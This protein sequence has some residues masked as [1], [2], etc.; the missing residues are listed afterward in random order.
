MTDARLLTYDYVFKSIV[1]GDSGVGKSSL[2]A[3]LCTRSFDP[4]YHQTIGVDFYSKILDI[5]GTP[6]KLQM[7]DLCGSERFKS[8]T[9]SYYRNATIAFV[10]YDC[11]SQRTFEHVDEWVRLV[12][13]NCEP[14]CVLVLVHHKIDLHN[15]DVTTDQ[16]RS[17][18]REHNMLFFETSSKTCHG[19]DI[20][21][22]E[23][24][25]EAVNKMVPLTNTFE[26]ENVTLLE[27][28]QD[29]LCSGWC[30]TM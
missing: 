12:R 18:A 5:K 24:V 4:S 16:G 10:V 9:Q 29:R 3:A 19:I 22:N 30:V 26:L 2:C 17:F 23:S 8:I 21:F 28:R 7:W 1:V 27:K 6:I 11:S 13:L 14:I 25:A 15:Q 20:L